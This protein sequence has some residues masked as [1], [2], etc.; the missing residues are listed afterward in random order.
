VARWLAG[1]VGPTGH[2]VATDIDPR[3]LADRE[4]AGVEVRRHDITVDPIEE[5]SYDLVHCRALLIHMRDPRR[6]CGA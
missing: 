4:P 3:F 6:C 5:D 1:Q 2:V